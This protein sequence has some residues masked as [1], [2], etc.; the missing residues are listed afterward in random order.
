MLEILGI[1]GPLFAA[2]ALGFIAVRLAFF[3]KADIR[4][5]G[6]FVIA[7][8]LP[9]L[10]FK[11]LAERS[12]ADILNVTYLA[13]YG[14]GSLIVLLIGGGVAYFF[15]KQGPQ[16]SAMVGLGMSLSNSGF[17]GYP[18]VL[19]FLGP[20][21]TVA[22]AL[23]M[24]IE[25]L[26]ILPLVFALAESRADDGLVRRWQTTVVVIF[27]GFLKNP[28]ILAITFGF[29]SSMSGLSLPVAVAKT[30]DMFAM[31][32][33]AVALFVIGGTLVGL[34]LKGEMAKIILICVGKLLLHPL[35]VFLVLLVLPP[36]DP[37]LHQAALILA[38][39]PMLSV[40][41]IL[42]QKYGQ[43]E[44]CAAVLLAA[45]VTSF[46]TISAMLWLVSGGWVV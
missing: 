39:I 20:S 4:V 12:F 32:S 38:C 5:L 9:A 43:E 28:L 2:M 45:T 26:L 7:I 14:L 21:A 17:I 40:Y 24:I 34:R 46:V 6:R 13:G 23:S 3:S 18:V 35:A 31:A 16:A 15:K 11:A 41:P 27:R 30:I 33:G 25:N 10:L 44:W 42:A 22:V 19:Q 1:T 37:V 29:I 36:I 8:A